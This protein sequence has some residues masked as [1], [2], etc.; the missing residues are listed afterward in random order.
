M[1]KSIYP[2]NIYVGMP[3]IPEEIISTVEIFLKAQHLEF[4]SNFKNDHI[5]YR[6][7]NENIIFDAVDVNKCP[8]MIVITDAIKKAALEL[9]Y[10][11]I[12]NFDETNTEKLMLDVNIESCKINLMNTGYRLGV[13]THYGDDAFCCFYFNDVDPKDGGQLILYDARWQKNYWFG[14]SKLEKI[15]PKR[16]MLVIAP[17]FIWHEV[18]Q[19]NGKED[20]LTLVANVQ[21]RNQADYVRN[22][23]T[24]HTT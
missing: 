10:S 22:S 3:D 4:K 7:G 11:N 13:H 19:Y 5:E 6:D 12:N 21:I 9:A 20:R 14:G 2:T 18:S 24:P 16:G 23:R 15:T 1:I 8:E 17:S